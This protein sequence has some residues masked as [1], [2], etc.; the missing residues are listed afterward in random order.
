MNINTIKDFLDEY[1]IDDYFN[2]KKKYTPYLWTSAFGLS[3]L[4]VDDKPKEYVITY[5]EVVHDILG[6]DI[7]GKSLSEKN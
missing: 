1:S 6:K 3:K 7:D 4:L 5:I 2:L